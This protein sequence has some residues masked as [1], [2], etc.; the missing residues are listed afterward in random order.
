MVEGYRAARCLS[1]FCKQNSLD[2]PIL[3]QIFAICYEG[4]DPQ[5]A[6]QNLM[7][8]ELRSE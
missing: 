4:K 7:K 2:A 5:L 8:R 3:E 6:L 1:E